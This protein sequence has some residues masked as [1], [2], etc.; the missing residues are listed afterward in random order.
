MF[1]RNVTVATF[2]NLL[3]IHYCENFKISI[4]WVILLGKIRSKEHKYPAP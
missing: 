1:K 2:Q 4:R 3:I